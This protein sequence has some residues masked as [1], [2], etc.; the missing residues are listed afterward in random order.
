MNLGVFLKGHAGDD[1]R[2]DRIARGSVVVY[3]PAITMGLAVQPDVVEGLAA[4]R[5]FRGRGLTPRFLYSLPESNIG[6]RDV[7]PPIVPPLVRSEYEA[8]LSQL[9]SIQPKADEDEEERPRSL[10]LSDA[11][12]EEL[13]RFAESAELELGPAGNLA[14]IAEWGSKLVGAVARIAGLL[15]LAD[16]PTEAERLK[17]GVDV[18]NRAIAIGDYLIPHAKAAFALMGSDP[19]VSDAQYLIRHITAK[20]LTE[21]TRRDLFNETR[22]RF[23]KVA[24]MDPAL[25]LLVDHGYIWEREAV[26]REGPGRKPSPTFDVN[27]LLDPQNPH[28]TQK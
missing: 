15:H 2:T 14:S 17:V 19:A 1:I 4:N 20:G 21:F 16:A 18:I 25:D 23:K 11:A 22:S 10:N 12:L 8:N 9:F 5:S 24:N 27:P 26:P 6:R 13:L 3:K 28:N 7:K